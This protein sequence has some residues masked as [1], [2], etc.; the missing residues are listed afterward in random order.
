MPVSARHGEH[1][2]PADAPAAPPAVHA[3]YY[4]ALRQTQQGRPSFTANSY[5]PKYNAAFG[6]GSNMGYYNSNWNDDNIAKLMSNIGGSTLR[7]SLPEYFLRT[8]GYGVRANTFKNYATMGITDLT[9]TV[10]DPSDAVR[11][12]SKYNGSSESKVFANLYQPI[13]NSNGTVNTNNYYANYIYNTVRTYGQ[14]V[15]FWEIMNEP[16]FSS[17]NTNNWY[18][19]NPTAA[20]LPNLAAPFP[21]YVRMLR[22]AYE[23]IKSVHPDDY[24]AIGGIGY[25]SFLD[26]VL[27]N[28][29]NP[30]AGKV[31]S[32]YPLKGGAYFDVLSYHY[33]PLYALKTW[34]NS[35]G[36][37]VYQRH[38]DAA[39]QATINHRTLMTNTLKKYGYTGSKYPAKYTIIT[40]TNVARKTFGT[41]YGSSEYHRNYDM[42]LMIEA[43]KNYIRQV[44]FYM[45]GEV[46]DASAASDPHQVMGFYYNLKTK[47]PGS[48]ILTPA[49]VGHG[50]VA[51][52]LKG[53]S[54]DAGLT[55]QLKLPSTVGGAAFRKGS[56][57]LYALYAKTTVDMS[58]S[59][60]V[61]YT[62][63]SSLS[64]KTLGT[65]AWDYSN[66]NKTGS[67]TGSKVTLTATPMI[68]KI[69]A[70]GSVNTLAMAKTEV[71]QPEKKQISFDDSVKRVDT[72][73]L[74]TKIYPNP[75]QNKVYVQLGSEY[76]QNTPLKL[77][78]VDLNG[79]ILKTEQ[80]VNTAQSA[81]MDVAP[82]GLIPGMYFLRVSAERQPAETFKVIKQ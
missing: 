64:V 36:G 21:Y 8:W 5:V 15:R 66:T 40:E 58:E 19:R 41:L 38:S 49:G 63:P 22:I 14:Y 45:T 53:Y 32:A 82:L 57:I 6:Y 70:K 44:H 52:L 34:S 42:K 69:T 72:Q 59:K 17:S 26:A 74:L 68:F 37:F 54:Y 55:S 73:E 77:D 33:Y 75:V 60:S 9:A 25:D 65:Y 4:N 56:T 31:T 78:L 3:D 18:S 47:S 76:K 7:V 29:D 16:D 50:T 1:H 43:S 35:K 10:G 12:R 51:K 28:T 27:R 23:V 46:A 39:V 61:A 30:D 71:K 62:F 67:I 13:W 80:S 79:R 20:E 11:D 81:E 48:Q 2:L 24:I